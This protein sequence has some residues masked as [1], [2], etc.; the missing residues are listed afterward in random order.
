MDLQGHL[1]NLVEPLQYPHPRPCR[2][3]HD[4]VPME[5]RWGMMVVQE[6]EGHDGR[7][8]ASVK[9]TR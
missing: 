5:S 2:M 8:V 3:G 4:G 9:V 1:I 6:A 7:G